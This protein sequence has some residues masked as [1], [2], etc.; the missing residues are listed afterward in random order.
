MQQRIVMWGEIGTALKV[1]ITIQLDEENTNILIHAFPKEEATKELQDALFTDWKNGGNFQFPETAYHWTVDANQDNILPENIRVERPELITQTQLK[2][3]RKLMS[4]KLNQLLN[5]ETALIEQDIDSI[6]EFDQT[7]WDKTKVQWNKISDYQKKG[8]ISWE[9]TIILKEKINKIFDTLKALKKIS[10]EGDDEKL[11]QIEKEFDVRIETLQNKLIYP[12]EWNT[13]FNELKKIQNELK[14]SPA[15]WSSKRKLQNKINDIYTALKKYRS[16]E[17]VNK[18]KARIKQLHQILAGFKESIEREQDNFNMQVEKMKHYT[19]GK[20][21]ETEIHERFS[22][23]TERI[24]SKE[25]KIKNI[26][27]TIRDLEKDILKEQQRQEAELQKTK[28]QED[29]QQ[30]KKEHHN[31]EQTPADAE[32][33]Q[34]ETAD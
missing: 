31:N 15:K 29:L 22:H 10:Q 32:L 4:T 25:Q 2:W 14:E 16:T 30:T 19:R 12:D 1:L 28:N 20:L 17:F 26:S 33:K 6:K 23:I 24:K 18:T 21:S 9:Q 27:K 11:H 34:E 7:L 5:E 8:E 3:S 13:I